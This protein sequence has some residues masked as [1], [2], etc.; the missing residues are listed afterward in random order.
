MITDTLAQPPPPTLCKCDDCRLARARDVSEHPRVLQ[1]TPE[2]YNRMMDLAVAR[3]LQRD[4]DTGYH[5]GLARLTDKLFSK[6][7]AL[8][9][10][11]EAAAVIAHL[12][13]GDC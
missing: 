12:E 11:V 4:P 2:G 1:V 13:R 3:R 6:A 7:P 10:E 5:I 9:R 8:L